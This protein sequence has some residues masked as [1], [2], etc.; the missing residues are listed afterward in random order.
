MKLFAGYIPST[1]ENV[2][3]LT[4]PTEPAPVSASSIYD[5]PAPGII[6]TIPDNVDE[7]TYMA[8]LHSL[9]NWP[10]HL[11]RESNELLA[12]MKKLN[13]QKVIFSFMDNIYICI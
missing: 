8:L 2:S 12:A 9:G 5:N 7:I 10:K 4:P 6:N 1:S 11:W 13:K 3:I